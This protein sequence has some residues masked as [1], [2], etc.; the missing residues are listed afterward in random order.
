VLRW[1]VLSLSS[2]VSRHPGEV[3]VW[4]EKAELEAA[5]GDQAAAANSAARAAQLNRINHK[6]GHQDQ[7]LASEKESLLLRLLSSSASSSQHNSQEI[8]DSPSKAEQNLP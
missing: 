3:E 2:A 8:P 5:S 7:Y 4:L 1:A 6:W